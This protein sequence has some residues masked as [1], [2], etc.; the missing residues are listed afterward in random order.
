M[1]NQGRMLVS[2]YDDSSSSSENHDAVAQAQPEC[3]S[4]SESESDDDSLDSAS[5]RRREVAARLTDNDNLAKS[6]TLPNVDAVFGQVDGPPQFLNP[7]ATR[8]RNVYMAH[9]MPRGAPGGSAQH[10]SSTGGDNSTAPSRDI[11]KLAPPLKKSAAEADRGKAVLSAACKRARAPDGESQALYSNTALIAMMGGK[12]PESAS[13][14]DAKQPVIK[15]ATRAMAVD[16]FLAQGTGAALPR[17]KQDRKDKEKSKRAAGQ[18][19]HHVWKSEAEMVLR[20]QY[21]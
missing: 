7:E 21:D 2:G 15:K 13:S 4:S 18:S 5:H 9:I 10:D 3:P 8:Q 16:E 19:S 6:S 14:D 20:Q 17:R 11:A 1:Q 12:A